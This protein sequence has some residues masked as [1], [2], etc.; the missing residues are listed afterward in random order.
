MIDIA[1]AACDEP[2][3][4]GLFFCRLD[5]VLPGRISKNRP[6]DADSQ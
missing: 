2:T 4:D 6:I 3:V 5:N 1:C